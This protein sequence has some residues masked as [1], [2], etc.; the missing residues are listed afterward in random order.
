MK[1]NLT[2]GIPAWLDKIC[3]WPVMVYR[4]RKYGYDFR[5]IYLGE[6]EFTIVDAD[7]YYRLGNFKWYLI[8]S[9]SKFYAVRSV[10]ID[11]TRTKTVRLHREIMNEPAGFLVDHRNNDTLDNRRDN[12]R[13]AT[14]CQ[15]MQNRRV[16][17]KHTA[18]SRF[19]GVYFDKD[20]KLW[21][22][23]LR[24]NGKVVSGGRFATEVEA[25][26]ARDI[27]AIK[28][29]GEFARLNFP[30]EDYIDEINA[31]KENEEKTKK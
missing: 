13:I 3:S 27:A 15:N 12:L 16:R 18:S 6:G 2:I 28:Y 21:A 22:Y 31:L 7:V 19:T 9:K 17:K 4:R 29:H 20:R 14:A 25:A 8:G 1:I 11:D 30:R 24:A 26:R 10:K 23:Q 5:R